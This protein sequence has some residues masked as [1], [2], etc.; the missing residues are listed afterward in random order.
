VKII[1]IKPNL[2]DSRSAD[3][4]QPLV[5]GILAALTPPEH[6]IILFDERVEAIDLEADCDL[7]AITVETYTARRAYE[8]S[9][10]YRQR[11]VPV[12]MGGYHPTLFPNEVRKHADAVVIGDA[13]GLW[14]QVLE[15]VQHDSLKP[16]YT[17]EKMLP[18]HGICPDRNI[19]RD[20]KYTPLIPVYYGRGCRFACDFC[21]IYAFY[22]AQLR[23]RPLEKLVAE[24]ENLGSKTIFFVD[25]NLFI[26]DQLT[27]TFLD[28][29]RSLK[30]RWV[31]QV[32]ID[33]A[34]DPT[35][36][37]LMAETG[38][39]VVQIG[40][41]SLDSQNLTQM[42]KKWNVKY[43]DYR[44]AIRRIH[45]RGIMIYGSF[46]LGYDYDTPDSF[47]TTLDFALE[48]KFCLANFNPITPMP[49]SQLYNRV[50]KEGRLLYDRW[51]LDPK[52][53][54]GDATIIPKGMTPE[55]LTEGCYWARSEFNKYGSILKRAMHPLANARNFS[56]LG[57]F[58]MA[59]LI[60][61]KEIHRKQ[62]QQLGGEGPLIIK[63]VP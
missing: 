2:W 19:F 11:G 52:Y 23:Q 42:K 62:G 49:G 7:V 48:N 54:Y 26:N 38:C 15:D 5:F 60:S 39:M 45:E 1:F 41:E 33:I 22:Q 43:N 4:M 53:R 16:V 55:Q 40:F 56:N 17:L 32:S 8:I 28:A 34:K 20:K 14:E 27:R 50:S 44:T 9:E 25:D 51:W 58:L 36:L 13:E 35:L 47:A 30:I 37:D 3:A 12:V 18:L 21:S 46:I 29:I 61:R 10:K 31:C 57:A 24:I 6:E 59:N 63:V